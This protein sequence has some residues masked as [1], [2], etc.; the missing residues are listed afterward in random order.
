MLNLK[1]LS[2]DNNSEKKKIAKIRHDILEAVKRERELEYRHKKAEVATPEGPKDEK[3][4]APVVMV[5]TAR[6]RKRKKQN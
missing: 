1:D 2:A 4:E 5:A 6:K 3:V